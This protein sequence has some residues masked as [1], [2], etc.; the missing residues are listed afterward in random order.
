MNLAD[1]NV[2][3]AAFRTD[4]QEHASAHAWLER[5]L[6]AGAPFGVAPLALAALLRIVTNRRVF[7]TPSPADQVF[8][9]S[10][11]LL[12]HPKAIRI[13]AGPDHWEIFASLCQGITLK[14][15]LVTDAWF[16]ALAIEHGCTFV[17]YDHDFARFPGLRWSR[18]E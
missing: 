8:A 2:L 16:A 1:V 11:A 12:A 6:R 14:P 4:A 9:F 15:D 18:P 3:I 17:T 10:A 13:E 7:V 5:C